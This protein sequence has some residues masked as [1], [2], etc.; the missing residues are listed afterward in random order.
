[1][2]HSK[3]FNDNDKE[4][5]GQHFKKT[6]SNKRYI[7][8]SSDTGEDNVEDSKNSRQNESI[9]DDTQKQTADQS[10]KVAASQSLAASR[11][12]LEKTIIVEQNKSDDG[13]ITRRVDSESTQVTENSVQESRASVKDNNPTTEEPARN[14]GHAN[15][16]SK[17]YSQYLAKVLGDVLAKCLAEV[18]DR[19]PLD[20]I[21]YLA[22]LLLHFSSTNAQD[23]NTVMI[24][25]LDPNKNNALKVSYI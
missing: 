25:V 24:F 17:T 13:G 9:S 12:T 4:G 11:E 3:K 5:F 8:F 10:P 15:P 21:A 7:F 23:R 2:S 19:R 22:E 20:P 6:F 16:P 14:D 1:M 18:A